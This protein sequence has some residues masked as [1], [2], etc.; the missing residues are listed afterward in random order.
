MNEC[1]HISSYSVAI[2]IMNEDENHEQKLVE[3]SRV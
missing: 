2:E 3:E 1:D